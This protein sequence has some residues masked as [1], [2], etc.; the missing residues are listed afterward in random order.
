MGISRLPARVDLALQLHKQ[1]VHQI[2]HQA[3]I[4]YLKINRNPK[5][6]EPHT[7]HHLQIGHPIVPQPLNPDRNRKDRQL[8]VG[9]IQIGLLHQD[10]WDHH[11]HMAQAVLMELAQEA[12]V[13]EDKV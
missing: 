11:V 2:E 5:V 12:V 7:E 13:A 10:Q 1:D 6:R 4:K 8:I 3:L 9:Q